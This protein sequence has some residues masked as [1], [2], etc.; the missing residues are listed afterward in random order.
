MH[1]RYISLVLSCS[2]WA[3]YADEQPKN[4]IAAPDDPALV[5]A[6]G[7]AER[8]TAEAKRLGFHQA[9]AFIGPPLKSVFYAEYG[10][11]ERI[12]SF[13]LPLRKDVDVITN[14]D[15]WIELGENGGPLYSYAFLPS[16]KPRADAYPPTLSKEEALTKCSAFVTLLTT[17]GNLR[18]KPGQMEFKQELNYAHPETPHVGAYWTVAFQ[19]YTPHDV[20]VLGDNVLVRIEEQCGL[21]YFKNDCQAALHIP[22]DE[23]PQVT[24]EE[25]ARL[26]ISLALRLKKDSPAYGAY[27]SGHELD[28]KPAAVELLVARP[29]NMMTCTDLHSLKQEKFG[30]LI[31]AV[32]FRLTDPKKQMM[33]AP[34]TVFVDALTGKLAGGR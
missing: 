12:K 10:R 16:E 19:R 2:I 29:N 6:L 18:L 26:A 32:T 4:F 11:L 17:G 1:L 14:D 21:R 7:I 20:P 15:C 24:K 8:I 28:E 33:P 25:A 34:L 30:V 9:P 5:S 23:Q 3:T 31:W 13:Q 27:Y 22:A